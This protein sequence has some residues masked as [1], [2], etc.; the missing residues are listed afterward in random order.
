V[1]A[2]GVGPEDGEPVSSSERA[3]GRRLLLVVTAGCSGGSVTGGEALTT[4]RADHGCDGELRS[5]AVDAS[6]SYSDS[7]DI[8]SETD[9]F[10]LVEY[11]P[12]EET[13][14]R[15]T[16]LS[17]IGSGGF[18][19]TVLLSAAD[20]TSDQRL[21]AVKVRAAVVEPT[22]ADRGTLDPSFDWT[23]PVDRGETVTLEA[24]D[25][26]GSECDIVAFSWDFDGDGEYERTGRQVSYNFGTDGY[27]TVGLTVVD[28]RG[29]N[30]TA[31][32][33]IRVVSD[34]DGDGGTSAVERKWGMD[35][36]NHDM[37]NSLFD[38][39]TGPMHMSFL[40]PSG[41]THAV[42]LAKADG[43]VLAL[44]PWRAGG[45]YRFV[46]GGIDGGSRNKY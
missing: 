11:Q 25:R 40:V 6:L 2:V 30:T 12:Q 8:F 26:S 35:P 42:L 43:L 20:L 33:G 44:R 17:D 27:H 34:P 32:A 41:V 15:A 36:N 45:A 14:Q 16:K 23:S 22:A 3:R 5:F 19:R 46:R 13:W 7:T 10:A 28:S 24:A 39:G 21:G 9:A 18:D 37:D 1:W 38:D 29:R 4:G 31:T